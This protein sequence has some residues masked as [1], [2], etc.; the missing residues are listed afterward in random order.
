MY[1]DTI[2]QTNHRLLQLLS[3]SVHTY[4]EVE[5]TINRRLQTV[6]ASSTSQSLSPSKP[7]NHDSHD[8]M[9]PHGAGVGSFH[10]LSGAGVGGLH[11]LSGAG[12]MSSPK[13]DRSWRTGDLKQSLHFFR[14]FNFICSQQV[15]KVHSVFYFFVSF[16]ISIIHPH[17]SVSC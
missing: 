14:S 15:R 6:V 12:A 9:T 13:S 2:H 11:S 4:V 1:R 8:L 7:T 17:K 5:D 10:S 16:M 3:E